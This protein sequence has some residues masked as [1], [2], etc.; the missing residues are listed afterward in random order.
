VLSATS[1]ETAVMLDGMDD[2]LDVTD[3]MFDRLHENMTDFC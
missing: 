3:S 1:A 2:V